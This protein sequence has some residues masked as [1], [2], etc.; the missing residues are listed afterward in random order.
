MD[1]LRWQCIL[2]VV[3]FHVVSLFN[4]CGMPLGVGAGW[5]ALDLLG[6]L[7]YPWLMPLMFLLSGLGARYALER[8]TAKAFLR[9]R[10][11]SLLLPLLGELVLIAPLLC[12]FTWR[13]A[14]VSFQEMAQVLPLP[15]VCLIALL[16]G[17]GPA[18]FLPYLFLCSLVLLP[19]RG[20]DRLWGRRGWPAL[21][22]TALVF[23]LT[24]L[25][26][27]GPDRYAAYLAAYLMGYWVFSQEAVLDRLKRARLPLA[28]AAGAAFGVSAAGYWGTSFSGPGFLSSPATVLFAW[29][30]CLAAL[31]WGQ[32]LLVRPHPYWEARGFSIFLFHYLP[33]LVTA[34]AADRRGLP[35]PVK[36]ALTLAAALGVPLAL[37]ALFRRI[38]PLG[39][40]FRLRA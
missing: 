31:G 28:L 36:Y 14:G 30:S 23:F 6:Y 19:L 2:W 11:D 39:R 13:T 8:R 26:M 7:T 27:P 18:W 10:R 15:V 29:L 20:L 33:M 37:H 9:E 24:T 35:I 5:P 4:S 38:P 40:L 21:G 22:L 12:A 25:A 16:A 1:Q 17:M 34:V 32:V 3:V